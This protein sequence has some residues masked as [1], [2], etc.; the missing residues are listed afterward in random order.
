M[1]YFDN[2]C[3]TWGEELAQDED[4][5]VDQGVDEDSE[6]SPAPK[7]RRRKSSRSFYPGSTEW[8]DHWLAKFWR[9]SATGTIW[10]NIKGYNVAVIE[11]HNQPGKWCFRIADPQGKETWSS[12]K[13]DSIDQ[14]KRAALEELARMLNA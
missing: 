8:F 6:Q 5:D 2:D 10:V 3:E 11:E 4:Q 7:K 1:S 12:R 13:Y 9:T 14:A